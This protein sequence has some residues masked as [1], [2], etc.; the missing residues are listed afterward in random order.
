MI[1]NAIWSSDL[2][3]RQMKASDLKFS[4]RGKGCCPPDRPK[5][6]FR[7]FVLCMGTLGLI[8]PDGVHLGGSGSKEGTG[9]LRP[10]GT[11]P[12]LGDE[13]DY[14]Y[15][16]P[17]YPQAAYPQAVAQQGA[18]SEGLSAASR[19]LHPRLHHHPEEAE[20]GTS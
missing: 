10:K 12:P 4:L 2:F 3:P 6:A 13:G 16:Q 17:T 11:R 19:R 1:L 20:L 5:R 14:A 18:G 7:P 8:D 15:D 9:A